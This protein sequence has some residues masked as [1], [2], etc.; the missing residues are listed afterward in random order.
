MYEHVLVPTDGS[1]H[2]NRAV[3]HAVAI[4]SRFDATLHGLYVVETRTAYDNAIVDPEEVKQTLREEGE[5]ALAA[6]RDRATSAGLDV[7]TA[8]R[9]GAPPAEIV[10]YAREHGVDLVVMGSRGRSSFKERL[11]GS[12]TEALLQAEDLP[13]LVVG[14]E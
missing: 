2:A 6:L 5:A 7:E 1:D 10:A 9:K 13:V 4:A 8:L 11:L 3:E 12:A 14:R